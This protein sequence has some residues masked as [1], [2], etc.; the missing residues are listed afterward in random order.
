M[1]LHTMQVTSPTISYQTYSRIL[2]RL[3]ALTQ[4]GAYRVTY[5]TNT[6]I[7]FQKADCPGSFF[8]VV[9]LCPLLIANRFSFRHLRLNINEK[10]ELLLHRSVRDFRPRHLDAD[11]ALS[12]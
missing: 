10:V 3:F 11:P 7:G 2:K 4:Q 1:P 9:F 6:S 5:K 12:L 8:T